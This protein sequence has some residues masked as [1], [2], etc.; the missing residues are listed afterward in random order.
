M[1]KN[2]KSS[3]ISAL[4]IV[5]LLPILLISACNI[6]G[7]GGGEP[8]PSGPSTAKI[9]TPADN[10]K[11]IVGSPVQIQSAHPGSN[12]AR[13]ELLVNNGDSEQLIR[14]DA[15]SNGIVL[16]QWTPDRVG[17]FT[18]KVVGHNANNEPVNP[19]AVQ[20]EVI[21]N[22]I[23]SV[24]PAQRQPASAYG[25]ASHCSGRANRNF[26]PHFHR[27]GSILVSPTRCLNS[28]GGGCPG[29]YCAHSHRYSTLPPTSTYTRRAF[30]PHPGRTA[31]IDAA[32]LRCRP[33]Y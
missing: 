10:T 33:I 15:P 20:L 8:P 22:S 17:R 32:G 31:R 1:V 2:S 4:V 24:A 26:S 6:I 16:Q 30:W 18:L 27:P 21:D 3:V 12:V 29:N 14:A 19:L 13:V 7:I 5:V 28:S 11:V 9:I 25:Y 23:V